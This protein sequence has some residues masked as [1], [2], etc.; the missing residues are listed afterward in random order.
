MKVIEKIG[1]EYDSETTHWVTT[2]RAWR[3]CYCRIFVFVTLGLS[4]NKSV[5]KSVA[6]EFICFNFVFRIYE[7][8][9]K[10]FSYYSLCSKNT[11]FNFPSRNTLNEYF[12]YKL[13]IR[14]P[15]IT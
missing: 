6:R 14:K 15:V 7:I 8:Y 13:E 10:Y 9:Y 2:S 3:N 5:K 1:F 4:L 11:Y 12:I